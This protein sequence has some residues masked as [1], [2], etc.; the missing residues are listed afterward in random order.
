MLR[1]A[2]CD[3]E[4]RARDALRCSLEKILL[5]ETEAVAYEFSSGSGAVRWLKQHSGEIDLLF[6]DVEMQGMSGMEAAQQ[7]RDFDQKI[8]IVFV[9]GYPDFVFDGYRVP[10]TGLF[11]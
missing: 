7:I 10:G 4:S 5:E 9:T 3:D 1:I 6:L 8:I 2:I 11:T